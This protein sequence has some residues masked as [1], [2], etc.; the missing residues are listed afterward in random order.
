MRRCGAG[1]ISFSLIAGEIRKIGIGGSFAAP[2]LPHH[3]AYGSVHGGSV[4][5]A[6]GT[7]ATE[8]KTGVFLK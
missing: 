7:S 6:V 1:A 8:A 4:D 3:R 5:Y 2:S